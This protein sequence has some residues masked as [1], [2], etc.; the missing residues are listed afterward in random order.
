VSCAHSITIRRGSCYAF[1]NTVGTTAIVIGIGTMGGEIYFGLLLGLGRR[2][3]NGGGICI[4]AAE[5]GNGGSVVHT[6]ETACISVEIQSDASNTVEALD[7]ING[8][9]VIL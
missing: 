7:I 8:S 2:F 5:S 9:L 4:L 6:A 3:G 1:G